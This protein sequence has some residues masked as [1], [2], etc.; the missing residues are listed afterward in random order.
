MGRRY[1]LHVKKRSSRR[2]TNI[3]LTYQT[4]L[5]EFSVTADLAGQRTGL[6]VTGWDVSSKSGIK[7]EA[8]ESCIASELNG[9]RSG[10][11]ILQNAFG[12]RAEQ[13]S[14]LAPSTTDEARQLSESYFCRTARRFVTGYGTAVCDGRI[15]V[16][17]HLELKGL[18][19]LFDGEYYVV[20]VSHTFDLK[21]G[22]QT[23]FQVERPWIP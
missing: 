19:E 15:R 7:S 20:Q 6:S 10:P 2:S 11:G 13:V 12:K 8:S 18:G 1:Y 16:G 22:C 9:K 17:A 3:A 23:H 21:N 14:H 5:L 4:G